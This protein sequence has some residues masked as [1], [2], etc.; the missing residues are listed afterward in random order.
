MSQSSGTHLGPGAEQGKI[1]V[2]YLDQ[3]DMCVRIAGKKKSGL[4][5]ASG[6]IP[7]DAPILCV[8]TWGI[9]EGVIHKRL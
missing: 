6:V 9:H 1:C 3:K 5:L 8:G 2:V 7:R 4:V